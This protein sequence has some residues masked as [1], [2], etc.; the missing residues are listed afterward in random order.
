[1]DRSDPTPRFGDGA[2]LGGFR[3]SENDAERVVQLVGEID[4]SNA[5]DVLR[6]L[7]GL[8][9]RSLVIDLTAV[10]F[11]DSAGIG[12]LAQLASTTSGKVQLRVK[13][14]SQVDRLLELTRLKPHFL[15]VDC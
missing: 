5:H 11:I 9:D 12:V 13:R 8:E 15:I 10:R 7:E 1:M 14:A 6:V 2:S 4:L 3:W